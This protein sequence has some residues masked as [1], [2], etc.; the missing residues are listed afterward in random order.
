MF[1]SK[2]SKRAF[3]LIELLVVIAIIAVLV[4]LLLPA[5]QKVREAAARMKCSNQLKQ[6]GLAVH[7]YA[8]GNN[9]S[10][11]AH[12]D[13]AFGGGMTI[14]QSMLPY[15]EQDNIYKL[16]VSNPGNVWANI[17]N[18][19]VKSYL[20]P[21]DGTNSTYS[22][23]ISTIN[24]GWSVVNYSCNVNLFA[25]CQPWSAGG[26]YL[27]SKPSYK[28]PNIPDGSSNVIA[29]AERYAGYSAY[30]WASL[31]FH[32]TNVN[33]TWTH[34][35]GYWPWISGLTGGNP[36]YQIAPPSNTPYPGPPAGAHPYLAQGPHSGALM[37][38]MMDGSVRGV[39][40][41]VSS[42]AFNIATQPDDGLVLPSDW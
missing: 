32:P 14:Y 10:L 34:S 15:V 28:L 24:S 33:G 2:L 40:G 17:T 4:G 11:P 3:T 29:F 20:C 21:S 9:E 27:S 42:N 23:G 8:N 36:S 37:V 12:T 6:M 5:V 30:N 18:N 13:P 7:N 31:S 38:S 16:G 22:Q 41:G 19:V 1:F 39:N 25:T 35:F 26:G